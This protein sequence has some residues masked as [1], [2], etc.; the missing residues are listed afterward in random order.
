MENTTEN[1]IIESN[2]PQMVEEAIPEPATVEAEVIEPTTTDEPSAEVNE[3]PKTQG[4]SRAHKRIEA[5][6]Q[7]KHDLQRKYAELESKS[8]EVKN[9]ELNP[10]SFED[11]DEYLQAVEDQKSIKTNPILSNDMGVV[12]EQIN[13]K[14]EDSREKYSDFDEKVTN[15]SLPLTNDLL[16]AINE[17]DEAGE[18]AY[19]LASNPAEAKR[20]SQLSL[21]KMAIEVGKIELKLSQ[22]EPQAKPIAKKTTV[23]P[24]PINP[25]GGANGLPRSIAEAQTQQEYEAMRKESSRRS[26]GFI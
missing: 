23:T 4:K 10:D 21:G 22:P 25:V 26:N 19:Y 16:K 6:I 1:F 14:F 24:E 9:K 13:E 8:T 11:Y 7:E 18:V 15:P 12:I 17:S 2:K 20:L 5:L 3:A